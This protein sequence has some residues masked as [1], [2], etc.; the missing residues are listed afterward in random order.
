MNLVLTTAPAEE[1]V[2]LTELKAHLRVDYD[3]DDTYLTALG[4]MARQTV[5]E[6]QRRSYVDTTWTLWLDDWPKGAE[7]VLPRGPL[8]SVTSIT[9]YD[10]ADASTVWALSNV[11]VDDASPLGRVVLRD[12]VS[13]PSTTLR[14]AKAVAVEFVAGYGAAADVPESFKHLVKLAVSNWYEHR[15]PVVVGTIATELPFGLKALVNKDR[16][17]GWVA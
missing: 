7:I 3:T 8:S 17:G 15:E 1:P 12:G 13:W 6:W 10:T 16:L 2:S 14:A 5:E 4:T 9:Y 11:V